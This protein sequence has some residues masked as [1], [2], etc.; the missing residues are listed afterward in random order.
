[1]IWAEL[2]QAEESECRIFTLSAF[3][4]GAPGFGHSALL[5]TCRRSGTS[6]PRLRG[7]KLAVL[8][9]MTWP[10]AVCNCEQSEAI[11]RAMG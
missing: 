3:E 4:T 6:I 10:T 8:L 11:S 5:K 1:M 7:G 2:N 9:A